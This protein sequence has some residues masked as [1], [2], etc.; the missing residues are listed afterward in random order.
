MIQIKILNGIRR[1][2]DR[3]TSTYNSL[4]IITSL[5]ELVKKN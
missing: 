3:S 2:T 4:Q 1:F 5:N